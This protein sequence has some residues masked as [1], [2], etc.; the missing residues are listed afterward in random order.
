[1]KNAKLFN[2]VLA[3]QHVD[4]NLALVIRFNEIFVVQ[5][6]YRLVK[7]FSPFLD[8]SVGITEKDME[9]RFRSKKFKEVKKA[10]WVAAL[11]C[12]LGSAKLKVSD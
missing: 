6:V 11:R 2:G 8:N 4:V 1:M 7:N 5:V 3:A 12:G 9:L 10:K